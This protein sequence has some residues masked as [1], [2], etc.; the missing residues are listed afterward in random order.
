[1][2]NPLFIRMV[3][4]RV[5]IVMSLQCESIFKECSLV[6]WHFGEVWISFELCS[7]D[8]R[9]YMILSGFVRFLCFWCWR[10]GQWCVQLRCYSWLMQE[11][12]Y[13]I[14]YHNVWI[15][16][17]D[18]GC[19]DCLSNSRSCWSPDW[20]FWHFGARSFSTPPIEDFCQLEGSLE[21]SSIFGL[22]VEVVACFNT[23]WGLFD[24]EP[25]SQRDW[26]LRAT[27]SCKL[28]SLNPSDRQNFRSYSKLMKTYSP[29]KGDHFDLSVVQFEC[30]I[31]P[32]VMN[33]DLME[34]PMQREFQKRITL[35]FHWTVR[36]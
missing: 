30:M 4:W 13:L 7:A 11:F 22:S 26:I 24:L 35:S 5:Q 25:S 18:W 36:N 15:K 9:E 17:P 23:S 28:F 16:W 14:G 12:W 21:L 33:F 6:I 2:S 1:M 32:K 10:G 3:L 19:C 27:K 31:K 20:N 29:F 34:F 8:Y